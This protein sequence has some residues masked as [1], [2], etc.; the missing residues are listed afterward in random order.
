[1]VFHGHHGAANCATVM[2]TIGV[3]GRLIIMETVGE[4]VRR[5]D[6]PCSGFEILQ[7]PDGS[8]TVT[9][10]VG[11]LPLNSS[12]PPAPPAPPRAAPGVPDMPKLTHPTHKLT[13]RE[14]GMWMDACTHADRHVYDMERYALDEWLK[15]VSAKLG[16]DVVRAN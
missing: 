14:R 11:P 12:H 6:L 16:R 7:E 5:F 3:S 15:A 13:A 4:V 1:M 9:A 2:P 10:E 8:M